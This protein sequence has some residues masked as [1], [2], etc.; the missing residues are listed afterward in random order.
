MLR[1]GTIGALQLFGSQLCRYEDSRFQ[2]TDVLNIVRYVESGLFAVR[3][4]AL[5]P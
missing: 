4:R 3:S 1:R 2:S 5:L